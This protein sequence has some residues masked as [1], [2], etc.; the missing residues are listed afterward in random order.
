MNTKSPI[1]PTTGSVVKAYFDHSKE[2]VVVKVKKVELTSYN[3]FLVKGTVILI[4]PAEN[5]HMKID[6][7]KMFNCCFITEVLES[8]GRIDR[9]PTLYKPD[10]YPKEILTTKRNHY[11]GTLSRMTAHVLGGIHVQ[12][13]RPIDFEKLQNLFYKQK[14]GLIGTVGFGNIVRYPLVR[15]GPFKKWVSKNYN[16]FLST[17]KEFNASVRERQRIEEE[18]YFKDLEHEMMDDFEDMFDDFDDRNAKQYYTQGGGKVITQGD[19][20][21]FVEKPDVPELE[22]GDFM[23]EEWSII[24]DDGP[25]TSR[26]A[27]TLTTTTTL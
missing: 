5:S 22:V 4:A 17:K 16:K 7:D 10:E 26:F 19:R 21:V 14:P 13:D 24:D 3:D 25:N 2:T 1:I 15:K 18:D 6:K 8:D 27:E 11:C 12:A 23:P 20:F 9:K